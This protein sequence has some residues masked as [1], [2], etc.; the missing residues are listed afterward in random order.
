MQNWKRTQTP[1]WFGIVIFVESYFISKHKIDRL[2]DV[3]FAME[4]DYEGDVQYTQ[5]V[6]S[7]YLRSEDVPYNSATLYAAVLMVHHF[8]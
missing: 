7:M 3:V 1:N 8:I 6:S 4:I 2:H 5:H